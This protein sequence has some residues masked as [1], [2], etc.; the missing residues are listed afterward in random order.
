MAAELSAP[1][2]HDVVLADGSTARIRYVTIEDG[3]AVTA[4]HGRLS[5]E[6]VRLRYFGAHPHLSEVELEQVVGDS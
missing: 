5:L 1:W 3:P 4:L 2:G 6:T